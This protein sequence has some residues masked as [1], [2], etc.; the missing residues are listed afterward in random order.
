[1]CAAKC[2][3][4]TQRC[5]ALGVVAETPQAAADR[6]VG[7]PRSWSEKPGAAVAHFKTELSIC[8]GKRLKFMGTKK[9]HHLATVTF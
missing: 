6:H 2:A 4:E 8:C 3:C 1:M 5:I 9:G 7:P